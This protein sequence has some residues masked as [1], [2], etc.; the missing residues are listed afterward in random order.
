MKH[1]SVMLKPASSLCNLR[2]RYCFYAEVSDSREIRSFGVMERD[3]AAKI[4][5][6]IFSCLD[7]G[8]EVNLAFQG[9]EPTMAGLDFFRFFVSEVERVRRKAGVSYALQTNGTMLDEEWCAFFK[10]HRFLIG[11]SLDA[12]QAIHDQ[13]RL[14]AS[15]KGTYGRILAAKALLEKH[16]VDYNIL[17]VLTNAL[18]RHPQQVWSWL[19]RENIRYVQFI[20]CLG[21][22]C[23]GAT[24]FSLTPERFASF[25]TQLFRLWSADFE[26]GRYRSVKLFDD[27]VNLL[28][29]GSRN[30]CG[31]TGQCM[32][33]IVVEAD[34]SVYPCD[35]YALDEY[36][37]GNLAEEPVDTIYTKAAMAAFRSR[38]NEALKLCESC[39]YA[40][41]CGGGC[42]RM[43]R[44][45]CGTPDAGSCGYRQFLQNSLSLMQRIALHER[46]ERTNANRMKQQKTI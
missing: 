3:T 16:G 26:K 9:G 46:R 15:G 12:M 39:P 33:Q 38:P 18:A 13:N 43:R 10:E 37:V 31:L 20:P 17:T 27:L 22:L 36:R 40:P 6:N 25:Y 44:E 23:G 45:V 24:R 7:S 29:D 8:D 19:C 14:D 21:E 32:P 4:V 11:L 35:F 42:P 34:G 30:A 41:I 28:V 1:I 2:C 5:E